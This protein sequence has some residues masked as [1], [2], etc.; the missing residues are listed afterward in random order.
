MIK[1]RIMYIEKKGDGVSGSARIGRVTFTKSGRGVYYEGR[2]YQKLKGGFKT[3]FFD[4]E[5]GEE[6]WISGCKESGGD[7]LY[8]GTIEI[9]DDAR[10]EY[11]IEIRKLPENKNQKLI[12][13]AGKYHPRSK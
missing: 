9:D 11:W 2:L 10:E 6:I 8:S 3:N 1:P 7:R 5:T 4:A 13:D 12:R